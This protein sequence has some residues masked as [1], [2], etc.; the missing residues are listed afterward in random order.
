MYLVENIMTWETVKLSTGVNMIIQ[1][2]T[3]IPRACPY[4][5]QSVHDPCSVPMLVLLNQQGCYILDC[6]L[7]AV[8]QALLLS[9]IKCVLFPMLS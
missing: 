4:L 2:I 7:E 9:Q 3:V 1:T 8:L 6:C 5:S